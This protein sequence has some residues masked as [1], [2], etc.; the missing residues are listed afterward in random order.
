MEIQQQKSLVISHTNCADGLGAS[1]IAS[2]T[3]PVFPDFY[4]ANPSKPDDM[5]QFIKDTYGKYENLYCF[6]LSF[7]GK[8]L[9]MILQYYPNVEVYDH[10]M[11]GFTDIMNYY[12]QQPPQNYRFDNN[13]SGVS[14]AWRWRQNIKGTNEPMPLMLAYIEDGDLWK[15]VLKNSK[16]ITNGIY[17]QI[18]MND[19][20]F[21]SI[22]ETLNM[23]NIWHQQ[24]NDPNF[25]E[26]CLKLGTF[27]IE[28][29]NKEISRIISSSSVIKIGE[30]M[31]YFANNT[32]PSIT[33]ELGNQM[34]RVKDSNDNYVCD[35]SLTWSYDSK[36]N[37]YKISLRS[38]SEN[39]K[40]VNVGQIAKLLSPNGGGHYSAGGFTTPNIWETIGVNK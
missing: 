4:F 1:Y 9:E 28:Q 24:V 23:F 5:I 6:D 36:M 29:K 10:H 25:I 11:S 40:G 18:K 2:I 15:F 13:L 21:P 26:N 12:N 3:L 27:L 31:V 39:D 17:S 20:C 30:H 33:S 32:S 14:L 35:Y 7:G 22:E 19:I 16:E 38:R 8:Y 37:E 34:V